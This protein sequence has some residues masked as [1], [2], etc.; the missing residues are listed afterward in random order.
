MPDGAY[1]IAGLTRYGDAFY[2]TTEYGGANQTG[3]NIQSSALTL[4]QRADIGVARLSQE[5]GAYLV[6]TALNM[7]LW[8]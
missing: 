4:S 6:G 3:H 7:G 5:H 8:R 1:P 2:G